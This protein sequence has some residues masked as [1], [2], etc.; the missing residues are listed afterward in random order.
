MKST[1]GTNQHYVPAAYIARFSSSDRRPARSRR[2]FV[3]DT[4]APEI[5]DAAAAQLAAIPG[6]YD[7]TPTEAR[8]A[9]Y[10]HAWSGYEHRLSS[11]LDAMADRNNPLNAAL[12]VKV[13]VP[14]RRRSL[15]PR[16][17]VVR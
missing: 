15:R 6:L 4:R 2:V 11:A 10:D 14:F 12:W 5:Y 13:I 16:S 9:T 7:L 3:R 1:V 17:R 8:S